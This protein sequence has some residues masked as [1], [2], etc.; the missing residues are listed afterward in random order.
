MR[1]R[2]YFLLF[3]LIF[4][5]VVGGIVGFFVL[6]ASLGQIILTEINKEASKACPGCSL[7]VSG[8]RI[9][10]LKGEGSF[11]HPQLMMNKKEVLS[12]R[13]IKAF[14]LIK[15]FIKR[16]ISLSLELVDGHADGVGP[17]SGTYSLIDQFST[18][19]KKSNPFIKIKLDS[20]GIKR[21]TFREPLKKG[22]IKGRGFSLMLSRRSDGNFI[23]VPRLKELSWLGSGSNSS[24]RIGSVRTAFSILGDTVKFH[25]ATLK[26]DKAEAKIVGKAVKSNLDGS[27]EFY[28]DGESIGLGEYLAGDLQ[29]K[30]KVT[31]TFRYPQIKADIKIGTKTEKI[32]SVLFNK[33]QVLQFNQCTADL[34]YDH[35]AR[36]VLLNNP[37]GSGPGLQLD[38]KS[39]FTLN[40]DILTSEVLLSLDH[41]QFEGVDGYGVRVLLVS[42]GSIG[43]K[44]NKKLKFTIDNVNTGYSE[45]QNIESEM[46]WNNKGLEI[47]VASGHG[48]IAG[49][50]VLDL[51]TYAPKYGNLTI[52]DLS[53]PYGKS[54]NITL[55]GSLDA[56]GKASGQYVGNF[57]SLVKLDENKKITLIHKILGSSAN[58][59]VESQDEA[60]DIRSKLFFPFIG[61][62][63][64]KKGT[65]SLEA[66]TI[67]RVL[68]VP[69]CAGGSFIL[70]YNFDPF[71]PLLGDG[72]LETGKIDFGCPPAI[73]GV[74]IPSRLLIKEGSL[75]L[76]RTKIKGFNEALDV[77]GKISILEGIALRLDGAVLLDSLVTLVPTL[78]ELKGRLDL[79]MQIEGPWN[80][81]ELIGEAALS[82]GRLIQEAS[83]LRIDE[84]NGGFI[85]DSKIIKFEKVEGKLNEGVV[86]VGGELWPLNLAKSKLN[87]SFDNVG[88]EPVTDTY[89]V[90]AGA[91]NLG[92][93]TDLAPVIQGTLSIKE[94]EFR[95]NFDFL[96]IVRSFR[97]FL[98]EGST[99]STPTSVPEIK[100]A[101]DIKAER[102]IF[103]QTNLLEAELDAKLSII[104][105]FAEPKIQGELNT[106]GGWFGM[107]N[108]QFDITTGKIVF[109]GIDNRAQIYLVG[110]TIV[111]TRVG[112]TTSVIL[113]AKGPL[114]SPKIELTSDRGIPQSELLTLIATTQQG[115]LQNL[116]RRSGSAPLS[117]RDIFDFDL[118]YFVGNL[119]DDITRIDYFSIEPTYNALTASVQPSMVAEKRLFPNTF[120]R[121]QALFGGNFTASSLKLHRQF[122]QKYEVSFGI[123]SASTNQNNAVTGDISYA[124]LGGI[125]PGL[126]VSIKGNEKINSD[127]IKSASRVSEFT[128]LSPERLLT[129]QERVLTLYKDS[130][131]INTDIKVSCQTEQNQTNLNK[132]KCTNVEIKI[133]E[134]AQSVIKEVLLIKLLSDKLRFR[135]LYSGSIEKLPASVGTLKKI[136]KTIVKHLRK[137]NYIRATVNVSF[138]DI[139]NSIDKILHLDIEPG[140]PLFLTFWGQHVF[141]EKELR[142]R[143]ELFD[144]TKSITT[145]TLRKGVEKIEQMYREEGY[146]VTGVSFDEVDEVDRSFFH[147][148]IQE[149]PQVLVDKVIVKGNKK[150]TLKKLKNLVGDA[151][152]NFL[153]PEFAI[154]EDLDFHTGNLE[155]IYSDIGFKNAQ[156]RYDIISLP[157]P[158]KVNI[159]FKIKEGSAVYSPQVRLRGDW[160]LLNTE[161]RKTKRSSSTEEKNALPK[162]PYSSSV[163]TEYLLDTTSR[164]V[165]QGFRTPIVSSY[166]DS[167]QNKMIF[168]IEKGPQ[169][170]IQAITIEGNVLVAAQEIRR[171]IVLNEGDSWNEELLEQGRRELIKTGLF[172]TVEVLAADNAIDELKENLIVRV[173]EKPLRSAV[174]GVGA[175]S[176]FGVHLFGEIEDQE[177]FADGRKL[178]TRADIFVDSAGAG[179]SQ[180]VASFLYT[181]PH[182]FESDVSLLSDLRYQKITTLTQEFDVERLATTSSVNFPLSSSATT[183]LGYTLAYETVT[184]APPDI[185]LSEYDSGDMIFGFLNGSTTFDFRDQP[186]SP[187][188]GF[189]TTLD[190]KLASPLLLSQPAFYTVGSRSTGLLPLSDRFTVA[191][192]VRLGWSDSFDKGG[193]VPISQRFYLGGRASMRGFRENSLGPLSENNR[194]IGGEVVQNNSLELQYL[195]TS[196]FEIHTFWDTG[197]MALQRDLDKLWNYRSS[198]GIGTRYLSPI[199]PI[200]ID[201]GCPID[202]KEGEP[203]LRLHF[204]I[205][206]QF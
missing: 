113:E 68:N 98:L 151:A 60:G 85:F 15:N 143:M 179:V 81:V 47:K 192:L 205:G 39:Y 82:K 117:A 121:A 5:L 17:G 92:A 127:L 56:V 108:R 16:E 30:G 109:G 86:S 26:R 174:V 157:D 165:A 199:G 94:A 84:L 148:Y 125:N 88:V 43:G 152:E 14:F 145:N 107:N 133:N 201:I 114:D 9:S 101:L 149:E 42:E 135:E 173:E 78:D 19:G 45:L 25:Y 65:F 83:S 54:G 71:S 116:G 53:F 178:T 97:R 166:F 197:N 144:E 190:Y 200:G 191:G 79:H 4:T 23:L 87:V 182:L 156:V 168:K 51:A 111:R 202:Q 203:S 146:L 50:I 64:Q 150:I 140:K 89:I 177:L 10:L 38:P 34:T 124:L 11:L 194:V 180:G 186:L 123:E 36:K 138:V 90:A 7:R 159:E 102:D 132:K 169:T 126:E 76:E 130:G 31:G 62:A 147:V 160:K 189:T 122:G 139:P 74:D 49:N 176:L 80:D 188:S 73:L 170:K 77:S 40:E 105:T 37:V 129:V 164:I 172:S 91:I 61:P 161:M 69:L 18:P 112:E 196:D 158:T 110:E 24:I 22:E 44:I 96:T 185:R 41:V 63:K 33:N 195:L 118:P 119:F 13:E 1:R 3:L 104:G 93:T 153:H 141:S 35:K 95:K 27:L 131:F 46:E 171:R 48:E 103:I 28:G 55:G 52:K 2:I 183:S 66:T 106:L 21:T 187:R 137:L 128:L 115:T 134:R 154:A 136:K 206:S 67:P 204:N 57:R 72:H 12:F 198:G 100:L 142:K 8:I 175:N 162:Y 70:D 32:L 155:R 20:L 58:I 59:T 184:S 99:W 29:G 193:A 75:L 181:H 120:I 6:E 163:A 167:K